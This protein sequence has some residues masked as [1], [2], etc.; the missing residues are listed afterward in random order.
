MVADGHLPL[1]HRL[2]Q[3]ALHLGGGTV[4][5]VGEDDVGEDRAALGGEFA[6]AGVI[7][8]GAD[9]VRGQQVGSELDAP[10]AGVDRLRQG[11]DGQCLGQAR[12][13]LDQQM[14]VAQQPDLQPFEQIALPDD[15]LLELLA[16]RLQ[17]PAL[18]FDLR[19]NLGDVHDLLPMLCVLRCRGGQSRSQRRRRAGRSVQRGRHDCSQCS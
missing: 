15:H 5:L 18:T 16:D 2:Q 4:D 8:E 3:R 19:T 7:H 12:N 9:Q 6:A 17:E 10:E 11:G 1:L 14:G 13:A